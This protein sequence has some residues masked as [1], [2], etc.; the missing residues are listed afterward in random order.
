M[1]EVREKPK[2]VQRAYLLAVCY[3][4]DSSEHAEGLLD[5]LDELVD[6]LGIE[7]VEKQVVRLRK[8]QPKYLLGSG[9]MREIVEEAHR[10]D[11]DVVVFDDEISPGQQR[12]WEREGKDLAVIDRQEVILDIF[13]ERAQTRE[14]SLQVQL[15][16]LEYSLPRLQRAWTHL[17]RQRGGGAVQRDAGETQLEMDQR[18]LRVQIA[19][20]KKQL[21]EV[22]QHREV[23]RK[24]RMKVPVPSASIV[25][26]TN[27]GK[28]T[29]L[30][31]L[32]GA[33][34]LAE[35]KLFATLDPTS[36]RLRLPSGQQ[37]VVTDTVGFVRK[38]PHRLVDAF[39]ATLEE[40]LVADFLI[41]VIDVDSPD[42]AEHRDTTLEVLKELG[43][44]Q[45]RI[46]HVYNKIDCL[47]DPERLPALRERFPH[48]VFLSA[49]TGEG[50]EQ[51]Y[52]QIGEMLEQ[53]YES[54][55]LLVPH[56]RYDIVAQLHENGCVREER[57][58]DDGFYILGRVP[59]RL[60][61]RVKP[62]RVN[63]R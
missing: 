1:F 15:A 47:D 41:H 35:D 23:Q 2:R 21:D 19:K 5:E 12:N 8:P 10:L 62:Y 57:V 34:V 32:T 39:K 25:G 30:N 36:R 38:L 22:V 4:D 52:R 18:L 6:T 17:N 37:L 61:A 31:A 3:P 50:T 27:A 54:V 48:D 45:K 63:G 53:L 16:R 51:L 14:A 11:C 56:H 49:R 7:V 59:A 40:A 13:A 24:Q 26:Y 44:D 55:E 29:L 20:V 9:K 28:S 33:E 58:E 43:A 46:I 60:R 42:F